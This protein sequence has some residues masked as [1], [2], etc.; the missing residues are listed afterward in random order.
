[1]TQVY[2]SSPQY[3]ARCES[4]EKRKILSEAQLRRAS[5]PRCDECGGMMVLVKDKNGNIKTLEEY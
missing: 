3:Y 2:G 5:T 4:C 1:M